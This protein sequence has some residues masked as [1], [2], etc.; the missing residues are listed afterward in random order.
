[1]MVVGDAIVDLPTLARA[2]Q[3]QARRGWVDAFNLDVQAP[4]AHLQAEDVAEIAD[5]GIRR[6]Y[7]V[8][9]VWAVTATFGYIAGSSATHP[10]SPVADQDK[11]AQVFNDP[12]GLTRFRAFSHSIKSG[13]LVLEFDPAQVVDRLSTLV[14]GIRSHTLEQVIAEE[15]LEISQSEARELLAIE[16]P[17]LIAY[18]ALHTV[19]HAILMA[20][21]R[22]LG[23]DAIG[24]RLFPAAPAIVLFEKASVGRGGVVQL[25]NRGRGLLELIR[26]ARDLVLGCAQGCVDGCPSCVYTRDQQCGQPLEELGAE[27][28]PPNSLLSRRGAAAILGTGGVA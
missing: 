17:R 4:G 15:A 2:A 23:T 12:E 24:S 20:A 26:A 6:A 9:E 5:A 10:Q 21:M 27:W 7:L 28:L 14:P 1:M 8:R 13:A 16:G 18:R 19:E 22:Q 25:V 3:N 11:L